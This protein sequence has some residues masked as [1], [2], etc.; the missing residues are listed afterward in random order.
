[1]NDSVFDY[2]K[3]H[4]SDKNTHHTYDYWY[5]SVF[6]SFPREAKLDILESGIKFGG[7]LVAW[8]EYFPNANVTGIDIEDVRL[9]ENK[10]DDIEFILGDI[11]DYKP[12]RRFDLII[13]DGNH[14]NFDALWAATHLVEYLKTDG[15]LIVEDIQEA[16][17]VPFLM[18]GKLNG[19]YVVTTVDM[20]RLT[21]SHDNFLIQIHKVPVKRTYATE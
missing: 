10:R 20:R 14:S 3:K 4:G 6:A 19:D 13:E 12:D 16:Y 5:N 17:M 2:L 8:K 15:I 21:N 18:W 9:E 11:K 1:M 7:S